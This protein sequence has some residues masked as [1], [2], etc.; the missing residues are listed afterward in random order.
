MGAIGSGPFEN[1]DALDF[2]DD[3][4]QLPAADR[5]HRVLEALDDVLLAPGFVE[6]SQMSEAVAGAAAVGASVN[7]EAAVGEPYL[8]GWLTTEPLPTGDEELV[9]K[10]RQVLRRAVRSRDNEWWELWDEAGLAAEVT[11]SCQRALG[12]LGDRDD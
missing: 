2:L 5:G 10:A 6:A 9:E 11:A 3:L 1:D 7:P 8:P 12:W 4:A